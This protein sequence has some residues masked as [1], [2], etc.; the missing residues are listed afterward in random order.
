MRSICLFILQLSFVKNSVT[1]TVTISMRTPATIPP[2]KQ[3]QSC[4]WRGVKPSDASDWPSDQSKS[5][6]VST[7][8]IRKKTK[9]FTGGNT[10]AM[11][12]AITSMKKKISD[13]SQGGKD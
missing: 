7:E 11:N 8:M 5:Q 13:L 9:S 10:P 6:L 2:R 3:L 1:I 12:V 4:L